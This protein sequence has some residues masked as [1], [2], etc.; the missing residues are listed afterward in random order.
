M[1]NTIRLKPSVYNEIV[2]HFRLLSIDK[3]SFLDYLS[4]PY[5]IILIS[6][7][8]ILFF[9][10]VF[11]VV[12]DIN[13]VKAYEVDP[14]SIIASILSLYQNSYNMNAAYHSSSYGWT[15]YSINYF[16]L[17]PIYLAKVLK[18]VTDDYFF[19]VGLRFIFFMIGL[20][21]VFAYFEVAKRIL[22][23]TFLS[24]MATFLYIASPA[25][26]PNFYFLHPESTGLL[27][28][29]I[30]VLCLLNFND[31]KAENYRWYT[32]G[33]FSLVLSALSKQVFFITALPVLFLFYYLYCHHHNISILKFVFSRQFARILLSS[34]LLSVFVF[35]VIN[36]F[37]FI[38][39]KIFIANQIRVF[40][41]QTQ[42][43][44][45]HVEAV[46]KWLETIKKIPV[47]YLSIILLPFTLLGAIIFGRDQK[48]GKIFYIVNI[49]GSCFYVIII[50]V[51]ARYLIQV[52]YFAPIYPFFVLNLIN[53]PL[54]IVRK[55]NINIIKSLFMIPLAY[56]LFFV[57][58]ADFSISIPKGYARLMYKN[59]HIYK[60]YSYIEEKIP[61]GSK[62]AYD[63]HVAIPSDKG[64]TSCHFWQGCGTD[65]IEKFQPDYVIFQENWTL[66]GL[67]H[68]QT[69]R[70]TKYVNDHHFILID[71]IE[72]VSVWKK[73]GN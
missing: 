19:F 8:T 35:F 39:P 46:M 62:V 38:Q 66:N 28:L 68:P 1:F 21:S 60:V 43:S 70:L 65:Y 3:K 50:S 57:L 4:S 14:G 71:T 37:A 22:K 16:L 55:W 32:L 67:P 69:E 64:I 30:G 42:G 20:S 52:T 54:Y 15:Y 26:Y 34:T 9:P 56:F 25:V 24:F 7:F 53:I 33:L 2:S 63:H 17:M 36:P 40:M 10:H 11:V 23:H 51:S 12:K 5:R 45:F 41:N 59:S 31:G 61:R 49:I 48:V 47:I 6:I 13:F 18:I 73:P 58:V 27:F 72:S 44:I 29:F